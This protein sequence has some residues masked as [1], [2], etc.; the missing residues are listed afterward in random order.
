MPRRYAKKQSYSRNG[1]PG[2]IKCGKMVL[3]DAQRALAMAKYLKGIVNVEYKIMNTQN[4]G[5]AIT[6]TPIITA[7]T[8][9]QQGDTNTTRDGSNVKVVS[10]YWRY[11][12]LQH[13][14]ATS[15]FVRCMVVVDKQTNETIFEI[16][17]L[18]SDVTAGDGIVSPRQLDHMARFSVLY[19][20]V[21]ALSATG[22][23]NSYHNFYKKMQLKLRYDANAGTIADLTMS[24]IALVFISNEATNTPT[25]TSFVRCRFVDN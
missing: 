1:R 9:L 16:G 6:V 11:I 23:T 7:I 3:T 21:H 22:Q 17:D 18:L 4:T 15:T 14:S 25:I 24:S 13:A 5:T 2:Y 8:N 12:L 20:K 10:L 19:D